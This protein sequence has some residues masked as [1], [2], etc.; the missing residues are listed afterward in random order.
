MKPTAAQIEQR[1][2]CAL[3]PSTQDSCI[4]AAKD[5]TSSGEIECMRLSGGRL[6]TLSSAAAGGGFWG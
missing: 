3:D 4:P 6:P 2:G 1:G 5:E